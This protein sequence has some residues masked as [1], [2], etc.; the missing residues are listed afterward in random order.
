MIV[1]GSL[2]S[3]ETRPLDYEYIRTLAP[4]SH[5]FYELVSYK[6]Y[7]A[8]KHQLAEAKMLYSEFYVPPQQRYY[9]YEA[10]RN[11]HCRY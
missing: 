6:I 4:A 10:I 8:L 3:A 7:A 5:R 9:D 2:N 1:I 11:G